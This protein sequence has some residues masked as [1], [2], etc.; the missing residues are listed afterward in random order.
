[1]LLHDALI[2]TIN[3]HL[4]RYPDTTDEHILEALF[5]TSKAVEKRMGD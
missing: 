2:R 1:M 4:T 3:E 5:V